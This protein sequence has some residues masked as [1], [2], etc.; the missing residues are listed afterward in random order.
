M[1]SKNNILR[2]NLSKELKKLISFDTSFP[3]GKTIDISNYIFKTL[4]VNISCLSNV[5]K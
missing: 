1:I 5:Y 4:S 2:D 3:P